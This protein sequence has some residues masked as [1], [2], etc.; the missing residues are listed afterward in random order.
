MFQDSDQRRL[1]DAVS[2]IFRLITM[3]YYKEYVKRSG[4]QKAF[5]SSLTKLI[6]HNRRQ[7]VVIFTAFWPEFVLSFFVITASS[8]AP[9]DS[10]VLEDAGIEPRTLIATLAL[11]VRGYLTS[12]VDLIHTHPKLG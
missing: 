8:S 10:I 6:K 3:D 5:L 4:R 12:R 2:D 11:A 9:S 1:I 7:I